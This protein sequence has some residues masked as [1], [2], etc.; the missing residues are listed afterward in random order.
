M[1]HCHA[2]P[3]PSPC[4]HKRPSAKRMMHAQKDAATSRN[5]GSTRLTTSEELVKANA[6]MKASHKLRSSS[7][8]AGL[9]L[10][11]GSKGSRAA[12]RR[13]NNTPADSRRFAITASARR[14]R[15]SAQKSRQ[16]QHAGKSIATAPKGKRSKRAA[17]ASS[18]FERTRCVYIEVESRKRI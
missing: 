7:P 13:A 14:R 6:A 11:Q 10:R 2:K 3:I 4:Q 18:L 1:L 17:D 15:V 9:M 12:E 8:V 5:L 16:Q